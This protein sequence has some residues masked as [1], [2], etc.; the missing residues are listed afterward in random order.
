MSPSSDFSTGVVE[1]GISVIDCNRSFERF[2]ELN[3]APAKLKRC[4]KLQDAGRSTLA[5]ALPVP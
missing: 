1:S 2:I 4:G 5:R 3:F